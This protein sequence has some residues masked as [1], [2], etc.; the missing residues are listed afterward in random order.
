MKNEIIIA[1]IGIITTFTSGLTSWFFT[2]RKYN[3]EVD[4][5]RI[6]NM[7][8]SLE[9]YKKLSD[10]NKA[11]LEDLLIRNKELASEVQELRRQ[12]LTLTF[13]ICMDLTC[14]TRVREKQN[15][16]RINGKSKD[17]FDQSPDPCKG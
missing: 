14:A 4:H 3:S 6:D 16:K 10:S 12:V 17:R 9:F 1:A 8:A 13:N 11:I 15:L 2:R 5:S 7:S